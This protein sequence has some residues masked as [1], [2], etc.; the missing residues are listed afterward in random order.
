MKMMNKVTNTGTAD[1]AYKGLYRVGAVA[2]LMAAVFFRRNL[3]QEW[4][5][6]RNAGLIDL[7]PATSPDTV[8]GWFNLLQQYRLLGLTL[9]NLFDL[10]NYAL[11]GLIFLSLCAALRHV[12]RSFITLAAA[13]GFLGITIYFASNQAFSMLSLSRQYAAANTEHQ[14]AMLLAAGQAVLTIHNTAVFLGVGY[15]LSF[16][17]VSIAGLIIATV[18]LRSKIFSRGSAYV[19]ILANALGL[20]Y[21]ISLAFAPAWVFIPLSA[22]VLLIWYLLIGRQLWK[23]SQNWH[24]ERNEASQTC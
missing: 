24:A 4:L 18:M 23:T 3:D 20:G 21:Y 5:L 17:L 7:G 16:L 10:V 1:L 11:V 14:K 12:S 6:L 9:L 22:P 8:L 15:Y 19:G 2:A 13:L